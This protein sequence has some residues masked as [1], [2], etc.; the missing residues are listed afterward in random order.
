M[1]IRLRTREG[2]RRRDR[3]A[4]CERGRE[5]GVGLGLTREGLANAGG[6]RR[7]M[8]PGVVLSDCERGS[9]PGIRIA[10]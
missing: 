6:S 1:V 4:D 2:A 5:P 8:E 9:E 7:R 3:L 10:E